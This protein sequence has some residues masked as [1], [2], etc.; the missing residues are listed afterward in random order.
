MK[1]SYDEQIKTLELLEKNLSE[2]KKKL[3]KLED[4]KY[5][6]LKMIEINAYYSKEYDAYR[7]FFKLITIVG[8]CI[9]F[10]VVLDYFNIFSGFTRFLRAVIFIIGGVFIIKQYIGMQTRSNTNYDEY[11]WMAAP[12]T[13]DE[14]G[15]YSSSAPIV[16][17]SGVNVPYICAADGCCGEG[18][19]WKDNEGCVLD[20]NYNI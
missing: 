5:N 15:V 10:T 12:T 3:A 9:L 6:Q 20:T 14:F 17:I 19:I 11:T 18:T 7:Q 13:K 16:D 1:T 8:L 2:A 4:Q